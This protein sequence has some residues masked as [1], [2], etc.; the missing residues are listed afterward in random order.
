MCA[1]IP[2]SGRVHRSFSHAFRRRAL[3]LRFG[4]VVNKTCYIEALAHVRHVNVFGFTKLSFEKWRD[5]TSGVL[6]FPGALR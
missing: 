6:V 4:S 5:V 3:L 2:I 1:G